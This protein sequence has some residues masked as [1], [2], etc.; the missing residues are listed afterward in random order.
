M[1]IYMYIPIQRIHLAT[2]KNEWSFGSPM[3]IFFHVSSSKG[4]LHP[5]TTIF[6]LKLRTVTGDD[7]LLLRS[8]KDSSLIIK[9]G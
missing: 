3:I 9:N 8:D 1:Y 5:F 6:G 4:S 7:N 2:T